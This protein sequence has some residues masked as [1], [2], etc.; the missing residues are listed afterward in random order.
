MFATQ[1][2]VLSFLI[3]YF[4]HV[5]D[6]FCWLLW[7]TVNAARERSGSEQIRLG[8]LPR[9]QHRLA[10]T[11]AQ[12]R[13]CRPDVGPTLAQPAL[14]S[15]W[16][17]WCLVWQQGWYAYCVTWCQS[18]WWPLS[19]MTVGPH[20]QLFT[21]DRR[22]FSQMMIPWVSLLT[23]LQKPATPHSRGFHRC[24]RVVVMNQLA[25]LGAPVFFWN[26]PLITPVLLDPSGGVVGI[27]YLFVGRNMP[28][29]NCHSELWVIIECWQ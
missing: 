15:G 8:E 21:P 27:N 29:T 9:Q 5:R 24:Q 16:W 12:R 11:L 23:I 26:S 17:L 22:V 3:L 10:P 25:Q 28:G 2:C 1:I 7:S 6:C 18:S 4:H 13:Y 19:H 20:K 14:L